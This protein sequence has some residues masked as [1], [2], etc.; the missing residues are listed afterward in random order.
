MKI[1]LISKIEQQWP[2][3]SKGQ[4][5]IAKYI[6][7]HYDKAA[8]MT[9]YR[10]GQTVG[11][12]ESTVVRFA[13]VLGFDG[14]P[15]LQKAMQ[16]LIRSKLTSVQR[17]EV[18]SARMK[19]EE[20]VHN[21]ISCDIDNIRQTLEEIPRDVFSDAVEEIV[22]A[23]RVYILGAGSCRSLAMF[24]SYYL[25]ILLVDVQTIY[26]SNETEIF[27]DMLHINSQDV[28]V[29]I[30][31]PR[32]SS[33]SVK[34]IHFAHSRNAKVIAITDSKMSPIAEYASYLLL[35]HSDMATIVDSLVAPLSIIN[36]LIVAISLKKK[37]E[38]KSRLIEL[39]EL[40]EE[41]DVYQK[42]PGL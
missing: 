11:V 31:F 18:T 36:A 13:S 16:E 19:Y 14:Y 32:Y 37:K 34:A 27:E 9:A 24:A 2:S 8:F 6:T 41:N 38:I 23:R 17:I 39:E 3:F 35:A 21:I 26:T 4:R 5:L 29:V 12:S 28:A 20:V 15:Q 22:N 42:Y 10:L 33:K 30:S 1:N 7:E 25:K 40:W